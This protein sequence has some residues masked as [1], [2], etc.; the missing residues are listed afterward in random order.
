MRIDWQTYE[1]GLLRPEEGRAAD[2]A[3]RRDPQAR[4]ELDGLRTLRRRVREA[5]LSEKAPQKRLESALGSVVGVRRPAP[6]RVRTLYAA[7]AL[8]AVMLAFVGADWYSKPDTLVEERREFET[9]AQ[10]ARWASRE[11]TLALPVLSSASVGPLES[12][13]AGRGWACFDY[14]NQNG[15]VHVRM[16]RGK[17]AKGGCHVVMLDGVELF[18]HKASGHVR[19]SRGGFVFNVES[20]DADRNLGVARSVIASIGPGATAGPTVQ[21]F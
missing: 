17:A 20:A 9:V 4:R 1:D 8:F 12:V 7:T 16:S 3:L 15:I 21:S 19:F 11:S 6:W 2:E 5:A 10:A 13:H 18:V 14:I